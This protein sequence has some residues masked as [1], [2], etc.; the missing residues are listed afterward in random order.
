MYEH[1]DAV[2]LRAVRHSDA[3]WVVTL[4]TRQRGPLAFLV[5]MGATAGARRRRAV[6]APMNVIELEGDIR[7][8]R[9]LHTMRGA[10][11]ET[12]LPSLATHPV[13]I[14]M[15]QLMAEVLAAATRDEQH[16]PLLY[17]FARYSVLELEGLEEKGIALA[18]FHLAFLVGLT[19]FV[20]IEPDFTDVEPGATFS[21]D[22]GRM[23]WGTP[24]TLSPTE[25]AFAARLARMN[26]RTSRVFHLTRRERND[27]LDGI[28]RYY[29]LHGIPLMSLRTVALA[30]E[31]YD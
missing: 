3:R 7:P 5:A 22:E 18:N 27:I 30:R 21:L 8:N 17:D 15:A 31:I 2:V 25:T 20:G 6:L 12:P 28:L 24:N 13:K 29:S 9:S 14:I 19:R 10:Q 26:Y 4:L 11:P 16:D 1:L 23:A